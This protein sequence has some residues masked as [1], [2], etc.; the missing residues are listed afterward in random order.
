ML[1]HVHPCDSPLLDVIATISAPIEVNGAF[2][3]DELLGLSRIPTLTLL[4]TRLKHFDDTVASAFSAHRASQSLSVPMGHG[5]S[6]RGIQL[7]A[8]MPAL[9][10]LRLDETA[11]PSMQLDIAAARALDD[12]QS[13]QP[14]YREPHPR[15]RK[16]FSWH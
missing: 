9:R 14:A 5:L 6:S 4:H 7:I 3:P 13:G 15:Y 11:S 2:L 12:G 1:E 16:T 8:S 10:A